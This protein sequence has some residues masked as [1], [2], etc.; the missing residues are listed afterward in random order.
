MKYSLF[1]LL[2]VLISGCVSTNEFVGKALTLPNEPA[3][4][5]RYVVDK[6][7]ASLTASSEWD[8]IGYIIVASAVSTV[9]GDLG[10]GLTAA[11]GSADPSKVGSSAR[12][13]GLTKVDIGAE[14]EVVADK[15]LGT[16]L[17]PGG[18]ASRQ[19]FRLTPHVNLHS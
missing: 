2:A 8:V 1:P 3:V 10:T 16:K 19:T 15:L 6:K 18:A 12:F 11:Q 9:V 4:A 5:N 7:G 14:Y 17:S 13:A